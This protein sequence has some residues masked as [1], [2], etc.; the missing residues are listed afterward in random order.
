[1]II[2]SLAPLAVDIDSLVLLPGNPR[3]G[4]VEAVAASLGRFGQRK[5][6]VVR[7]SDRVVI[8]GN[9]TWQ[10]AKSLGWDEIAAVLVDDDTATSEAFALADNR[11]AELGGYD[12]ALLLELIRSVG[13]MDA[14][15]LLD[16]GWDADAVQALVDRVDPGLPDL[17][18]PDDAPEPP[19]EP[20]TKPGDVWVLGGH[21][22]VCGDSTS[23]DDWGRL[24]LTGRVL[25][26][27]SPPYGVGV[28]ARLRDHYVPGATDR[29]SLYEA[30]DDDPDGWPQLMRDWTSMALAHSECVIANVQML[31]NNKRALVAWMAEFST[32][33][34][35]V[36]VWD[37]GHGAPQMQSN[38]LNNAWEFMFI[39]G[40][41]GASRSITMAEFHGTEPNIVRTAIGAS[42]NEFA[43]V[44]GATMPSEVAMWGI[45]V[46][47]KNCDVVVDPFGGTGTTLMAAHA[48][49][50]RAAIIELDPKYVDV[51]CRRW[52]EHTGALPV[53]EATGK[54]HDFTEGTD[55]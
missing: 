15:L 23:A 3:K 17:P 19:V 5:P 35:D 16:T 45:T 8:A 39:L 20:F 30:H 54:T 28:N 12:E 32:H 26:F 34:V 10:A 24:N 49:N 38:V 14:S 36:A 2:E 33:L 41:D 48:A 46:I 37:K 44:H 18:P 21:R 52:Q 50:K 25:T 1:M 13:E 9:H 42:G 55:G 43:K 11:T 6:I 31:A 53:L 22:V 51:I 4:D 29:K 40:K 7:A 27:T 47:G